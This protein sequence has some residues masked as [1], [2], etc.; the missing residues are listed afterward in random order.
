MKLL[1]VML[2]GH[3]I[4]MLYYDNIYDHFVSFIAVFLIDNEEV[5]ISRVIDMY[6]VMFWIILS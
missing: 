1:H 3:K 5:F 4:H 6:S 2:I